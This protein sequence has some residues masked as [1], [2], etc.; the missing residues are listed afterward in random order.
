MVIVWGTWPSTSALRALLRR[1]RDNIVVIT[2]LF[3]TTCFD[4]EDAEDSA[5]AGCIRVTSIVC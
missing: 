3:V 5:V 4:A 1:R 2:S